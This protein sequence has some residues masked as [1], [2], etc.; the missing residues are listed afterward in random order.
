MS[1]KC[2]A[3]G[4]SNDDGYMK[5]ACGYQMVTEGH[6]DALQ[7]PAASVKVSAWEC[8]QCGTMH[9]D[10][11][12]CACGFVKDG[13][14]PQTAAPV[15]DRLP[16]SYG[17]AG[18]T[19]WW[20]CFHGK[21]GL[22]FLVFLL[23]IMCRVLPVIAGAAGVLVAVSIA[24]SISIGFGLVGSGIAWKHRGYQSI[25]EL[26]RGERAWTIFGSLFLILQ[27]LVTVSAFA[28]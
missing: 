19:F 16:F 28:R 26:D 7:H 11:Y 9:S 14:D 15:P 2:L 21:V 22:G 3:C 24:W 4:E 12:I 18:I 10:D 20:L 17:A 1:W 23:I 6:G 8:P 13:A 25:D 27:V 5:C